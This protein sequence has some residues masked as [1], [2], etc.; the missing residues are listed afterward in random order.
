MSSMS[1]RSYELQ[2][3]KFDVEIV[4][5]GKAIVRGVVEDGHLNPNGVVHGGYVMTMAD[6]AG[7]AALRSLNEPVA[8]VDFNYHF[9]RPVNVGQEIV[10]SSEVVKW[11]QTFIAM[12]IRLTADGKQVGMATGTW[13]RLEACAGWKKK[14]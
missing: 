3:F 5:P 8:T 12:E 10:A 4:E 14:R 13:A 6:T 11:G 2:A 7:G 9:L 1:Y